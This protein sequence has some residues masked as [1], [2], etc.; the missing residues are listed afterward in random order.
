[1]TS[2]N[3]IEGLQI[4]QKSKP[5]GVSD[6]HIRAE[7]DEVWAGSLRW[8]MSEEDKNKL[9][10]LGWRPDEDAEGWNARF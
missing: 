1:M 4:I 8:A 5:D 10:D 7:H 6:Y 2:G 3:L 9:K